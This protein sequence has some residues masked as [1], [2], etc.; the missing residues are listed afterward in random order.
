MAS[1]Q[2]LFKSHDNS[3]QPASLSL[4]DHFMAN[5]DYAA[6]RSGGD[7]GFALAAPQNPYFIRRHFR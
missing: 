5:T 2:L 6:A 3:T 7:S 1:I 4:R